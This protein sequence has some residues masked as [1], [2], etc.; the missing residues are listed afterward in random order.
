MVLRHARGKAVHF[1]G[2]DQFYPHEELPDIPNTDA[3]FEREPSVGEYL[4]QHRP[5]F[6]AAGSYLYRL[7]PF[8]DWIGKYN[9][10]WFVGDLIAGASILQY[11]AIL[12]ANAEQAS[13]SGLSSYPRV[14]LMPS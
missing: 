1:L 6:R 14:W 9:W 2:F 8:I 13:L 3:F 11:P 4:Q 7:L 5:T 10:T 12:Q